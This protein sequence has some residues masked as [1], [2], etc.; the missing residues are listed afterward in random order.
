MM[1]MDSEVS[2]PASSR[3]PTDGLSGAQIE[4]GLFS[5][6]GEQVESM[7]AWGRSD[8]A[9][10]LEHAA[11]EARVMA[12]GFEMMRV[13]TEAQLA[14][15]TLRET[16]RDDVVDADGD[17]RVTVVAGQQ[18]TRVMIYGPVS[19]DRMA[20][21]RYHKA[22]LYPQDR[23]LNW[24]TAHSY[25]AGVTK[26]V[27]GT[28]A[29][30][31]FEQTAAQ[32]SGSAPITI[33]KRQVEAL[34]VASTIDFEAFYA[35]R[36]PSAQPDTV[37]LLITA[38]GS[39]FAVRPQALRPATAK[40]A[41]ARTAAAAA[42]GWPEDPTQ[43][44]KSKKRSAELVCVADIPP[45]PRTTADILSALFEQHPA[46]AKTPGPA[47]PTGP[48]A[49]GK[50]VFASAKHPIRQ[51][52]TDGFAEAHRRDPEHAREWFAVVDGNNAQIEAITACARDYQVDVPILIDFIHV[53]QYLWKAAGTFFYGHDAAAKDW[54]KTQAGKILDGKSGDVVTGIRRRATRFG[55][56]PK[57][58]EGADTCA[59]Y[60]ENKKDYLDYPA[61]LTAGRPVASGLIEGACRWLV[62]DRMEVTGARWGL[63]GA[64]AVLKLRALAGNGDFDD[65][66]D[67]HLQQE[68]HRN[69]D[70]LYTLEAPPR[71]NNGGPKTTSP[72]PN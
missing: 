4:D 12:E 22:N 59:T 40:A 23:D 65:Y 11:L 67:Y 19:S 55:Y 66:F 37:G 53:V 38:D 35:A 5:V 7:I 69:H 44:R 32:V 61:F 68:K 62:K 63:D 16:R 52:I 57:E 21:R 58:R 56:G 20:Y 26:R 30:L 33:G 71:P 8:E 14:L 42:S 18:H 48:V 54:V 27:A 70:N 60:L 39:A 34:A 51:V 45:V 72:R 47:R 9:L 10:G 64:E 24:S 3:P 29:F 6:V 41:Q 2:D 15:H 25:S 46:R 13:F 1:I 50:T 28:A 43:L 31:P 17:T 49:E 36:R